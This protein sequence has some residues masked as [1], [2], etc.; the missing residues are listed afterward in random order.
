MSTV[1]A[2]LMGGLGN[3]MFIYAGARAYS[4]RHNIDL[5][6]DPS[7]IFFDPERTYALPYWKGVTAP[8]ASKTCADPRQPFAE[9]KEQYY[10]MSPHPN[11]AYETSGYWQDERYFKDFESTIR[12][13]FTPKWEMTDR[14]KRMAELIDKAGKRSVLMTVR[15]GSH[16]RY[17]AALP[18]SYQEAALAVVAQYVENMHVF[19]SAD[20]DR[21]SPQAIEWVKSGM[22]L[23]YQHT[24][25]EDYDRCYGDHL[26]RDDEELTLMGMCQHSVMANSTFAWWGRYL[27]PNQGGINIWPKNLNPNKTLNPGFTLPPMAGWRTL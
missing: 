5:R 14:G 23:S 26:G 10:T 24:I 8:L 7:G 15:H 3:Q 18:F 21:C 4:L 25:L 1:I 16:A 13:D 11:V 19:V 20:K 2:K 6:I 12:A 27:S 22:S 9:L 17:N